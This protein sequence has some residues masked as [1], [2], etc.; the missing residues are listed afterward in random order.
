MKVLKTFFT[1]VRDNSRKILVLGE[2]G[3]SQGSRKRVYVLLDKNG[4]R[5]EFKNQKDLLRYVTGGK[6]YRD[7]KTYLG[8]S[9]GDS[10]SSSILE[11]FTAPVKEVEKGIDLGVKHN[12]VRRLLWKQYGLDIKRSGYDFEDVLQQVY[13]GLEIRNH[14]K[15]PFDAAK[16]SFSHYVYMV[17]AC[18]YKNYKRKRSKYHFEQLGMWDSNDR[19][20]KDVRQCNV[21]SVGLDAEKQMVEYREVVEDFFGRLKERVA[22]LVSTDTLRAILEGVIL[23]EKKKDLPSLVGAPASTVTKVTRMMREL[24]REVYS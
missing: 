3:V 22:G 11:L 17:S 24:A 7:L 21:G 14:G 18:V 4:Q 6:S 19:A 16:S 12:D 10:P 13:L 8:V 1:R 15:C 2:E 23:G 9:G 20:Y 5:R